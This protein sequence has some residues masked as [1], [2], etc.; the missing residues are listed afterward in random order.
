M[1]KFKEIKYELENKGPGNGHPMISFYFDEVEQHDKTLFEDF[2]DALAK[3]PVEVNDAYARACDGSQETFFKFNGTDFVSDAN[4]DQ[5]EEFL[6]AISKESLEMQKTLME[7]NQLKLKDMR[8]PY[9]LWGGKPEVITNKDAYE[10]FN[11]VYVIIN[12]QDKLNNLALV[13]IMNHRMGHIYVDW[14]GNGKDEEFIDE[15]RETFRF[16]RVIVISNLQNSKSARDFCMKKGYVN[17][18]YI[19]D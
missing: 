13:Q 7:Q 11:N 2:K 6:K 14:L 9:F 17:Y 1:L 16:F 10:M 19:E 8:P 3:M 4:F 15:M 18:T 5:A 12:N